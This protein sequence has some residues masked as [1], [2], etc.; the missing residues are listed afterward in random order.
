MTSEER[1]A[2]SEAR[3]A[4]LEEAN[5]NLRATVDGLKRT[6]YGGAGNGGLQRDV[7]VLLD[8]QQKH[9]HATAEAVGELDAIVRGKRGDDGMVAYVAQLKR[10]HA[11][12]FWWLKYVVTPTGLAIVGGYLAM[13]G[14]RTS[15]GP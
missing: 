4:R 15:A 2:L 7:H 3:I 10:V 9:V 6:L 11:N 13:H 14:V 5:A 1:L 8:A 12:I